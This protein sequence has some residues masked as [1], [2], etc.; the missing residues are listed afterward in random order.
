[1]DI[2]STTLICSK[3][4]VWPPLFIN[5]WSHTNISTRIKYRALK[6]PMLLFPLF[7]V[8]RVY[9]YWDFG[10]TTTFLPKSVSACLCRSAKS[11]PLICSKTKVWPPLFI[12][13]WRHT[14][15]STRI[16]YRALNIFLMW[17]RSDGYLEFPS[18][19]K[20]LK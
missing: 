18:L 17:L 9:S 12:N 6:R 16:K 1:V 3:T 20:S 4:K 7:C 8:F 2:F 10:K 15:I 5:S 11:R 19:L 13:S 14:N